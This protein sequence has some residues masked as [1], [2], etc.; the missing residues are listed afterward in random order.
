[1]LVGSSMLRPTTMITSHTLTAR[2]IG[3]TTMVADSDN[4]QLLTADASSMFF[5]L[6]GIKSGAEQTLD[7]VSCTQSRESPAR[8]TVV[9]SRAV[10][11]RS[12]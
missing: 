12:F 3:A 8:N 9:D 5:A 2:S 6:G 4:L 11:A 1:M 10:L 7:D